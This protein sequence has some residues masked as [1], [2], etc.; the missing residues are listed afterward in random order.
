MI[1]TP[2][3][4]ATVSPNVAVV[5]RAVSEGVPLVLAAAVVPVVRGMADPA[6]VVAWELV[7]EASSVVVPVVDSVV[8]AVSVPAVFSVAEAVPGPVRVVSAAVPPAAVG[9]RASAQASA[10]GWP[11]LSLGIVCFGSDFSDPRIMP[12]PPE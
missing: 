8:R 4:R 6:A 5:A 7:P 12:Y 3:P 9:I 10:S 11:P 1:A 2:P